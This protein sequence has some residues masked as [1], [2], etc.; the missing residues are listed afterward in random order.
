MKTGA[1]PRW[2]GWLAWAVAVFAGW[3]SLLG[4]ASS[5][6]EGLTVIGFLGFFVFMAAMGV[7]ILRRR[8]ERAEGL[9][10]ASVV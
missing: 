1:V 2:L 7:A 6:L 9:E 3:L 8:P 10:P 5:L 4:P